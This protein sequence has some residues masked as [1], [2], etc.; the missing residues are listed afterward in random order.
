MVWIMSKVKGTKGVIDRI[1]NA[2]RTIQEQVRQDIFKAASDI[3][4]EAI[5]KVPVKTSKLQGSITKTISPNGFTATVSAG[6]D[7]VDYAAYV[8]FGTSKQ[9]A[10]PYLYPAYFINGQKLILKLKQ[11]LSRLKL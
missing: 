11:R 8:E 5:N 4:Q 9:S 3:E 7:L 2:S 6:N 1:K 10:Q